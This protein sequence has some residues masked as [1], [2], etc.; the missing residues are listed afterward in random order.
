MLYHNVIYALEAN[1]STAGSQLTD[2]T[3]RAK[4][5]Q[6]LLQIGNGHGDP[7]VQLRDRWILNAHPDEYYLQDVRAVVATVSMRDPHA[8]CVLFGA[9]YVLPTR[10]EYTVITARHSDPLKGHESFHPVGPL[11]HCDAAYTFKEPRLWKYVPGTRWGTRHAITTPEVH[12]GHRTWPTAR[13]TMLGISPFFV[14]LKLH[15]FGGPSAFHVAANSDHVQ[16]DSV[17]RKRKRQ[18]LRGHDWMIAFNG[19]GFA[20]GISPHRLHGSLKVDP[21]RS[22]LDTVLQYYELSGRPATPL[23]SEIRRRCNKQVPRCSVP[24][25]P[26]ARFT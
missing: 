8:T 7:D 14:H 24:W 13:E 26:T 4:A 25:A 2:Q 9:A 21:S 1:L 11:A 17:A 15:D 12:P 23:S 20:T 5:M 3:A 10:T 18:V 16:Q 19:S 22:A 6:L